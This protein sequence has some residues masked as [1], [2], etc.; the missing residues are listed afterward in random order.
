MGADEDADL[1]AAVARAVDEGA[2]FRAR[3]AP[4]LQAATA[5]LVQGGGGSCPNGHATL[6]LLAPAGAVC[7]C[8]G[9]D[10]GGEAALACL[11]GEAC[12]F[13]CCLQASCWPDT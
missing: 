8:C 9:L 13:W 7:A 3:A 12:G 6:A 1:D 11:G 2:A 10:V 5:R 4:V